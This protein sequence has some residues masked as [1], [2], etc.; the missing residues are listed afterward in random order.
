MLFCILPPKKKKNSI[1]IFNFIFIIITRYIRIS[2]LKIFYTNIFIK[3]NRWNLRKSFLSVF[4]PIVILFPLLFATI[5]I[6]FLNIIIILF[7]KI[8][9]YQLYYNLYIHMYFLDMN[10][11]ILFFKMVIQN[12][13]KGRRG[14]LN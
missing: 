14:K 13:S 3:L 5:V 12:P 10:K 11:N 4:P 2:F 6:I 1:L 8:I 7:L 9:T